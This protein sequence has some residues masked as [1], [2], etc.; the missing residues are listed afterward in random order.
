MTLPRTRTTGE[1]PALARPL[2]SWINHRITHHRHTADSGRVRHRRRL[3]L[4]MSRACAR[5]ALG[6]AAGMRAFGQWAGPD[7]VRLTPVRVE[8]DGLHPA[9]EGFRIAQLT[10]VHHGPWLPIEFVASIVA[11][12]NAL[13]PDLVVLT[14]D[15]VINSPRYI[16]PVVR[17]FGALRARTGVA[18]TL[19]NHDW[20]EGER[21]MRR[22]F[23]AAGIP[24]LDNARVFVT[25][26][27]RLAASAREGLCVAALGDYWEESLRP[28]DALGGVPGD[29]PRL[30][31]SHNPDAAE[32]PD[33]VSAGHRVDLMISGH[34]HGGQVCLP[35]VGA[36]I[37]PSLY[38][39]KYAGGWV[40]GPACPVFVCNGIGTSGVPVRIG[41]P[42]EVAVFE[43]AAKRRDGR[44]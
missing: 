18:A 27:R 32:D 34:T 24:L 8:L 23:A 13:S 29:M 25:P 17:A 7:C 26:E 16:A 10:D 14:G 19:G 1:P 11:R 4:A 15:Y 41:A 20:W 5:A 37:V 31:L 43:L 40:E 35:R 2:F 12:V 42:A 36:P 9:L 6:H 39:Q 21:A 44:D 38:G 30:L 22:E 3:R 28:D 33:F